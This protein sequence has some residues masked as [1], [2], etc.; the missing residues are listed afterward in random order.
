MSWSKSKSKYSYENDYGHIVVF[1]PPRSKLGSIPGEEDVWVVSAIFTKEEHRG[2][3][4]SLRLLAE[5]ASTL[6]RDHGTV[7]LGLMRDVLTL[8]LRDRAPD[9]K[10]KEPAGK[11]SSPSQ[12]A[13]IAW[14]TFYL[15]FNLQ[16]E[17]PLAKLEPGTSWSVA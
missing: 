11:S 13:R 8:S 12:E 3:G 7:W 16:L 9:K 15:T 2:Q 1:K 10:R 17:G 5:A 14:E 6:T 4:H